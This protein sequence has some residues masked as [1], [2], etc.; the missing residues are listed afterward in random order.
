MIV[1][2]D[3]LHVVANL[4]VSR[5]GKKRMKWICASKASGS[6]VAKVKI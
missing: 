2:L 6:K 1:L 3:L 5:K 4:K